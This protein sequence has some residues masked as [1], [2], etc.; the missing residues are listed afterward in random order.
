MCSSPPPLTKEV[1][2]ES[3]NTKPLARRSAGRKDSLALL[4]GLRSDKAAESALVVVGKQID[5]VSV[6][7]T[8]R[9]EGVGDNTYVKTSVYIDTIPD[10]LQCVVNWIPKHKFEVIGAFDQLNV[11]AKRGFVGHVVS[12]LQTQATSSIYYEI[13]SVRQKCVNGPFRHPPNLNLIASVTYDLR[14][15]KPPE[16]SQMHWHNN[17]KYELIVHLTCDR[18]CSSVTLTR[19]LFRDAFTRMLVAERVLH[20]TRASQQDVHSSSHYNR[21]SLANEQIV[22]RNVAAEPAIQTVPNLMLSQSVFLY[23]V[24]RSD[25]DCMK[26][27]F[28]LFNCGET[29]RKQRLALNAW[30]A[31]RKQTDKDWNSYTR[32]HASFIQQV[33]AVTKKPHA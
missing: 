2:P 14:K 22:V 24:P 29:H 26:N 20:E 10:G 4:P 19:I 21:H 27:V 7:S 32:I 8:Q 13:E 9:S 28:N 31:L 5:E 6:A 16:H 18:N 12:E 11:S 17:P 30:Q 23:P 15:K 1:S 3:S 33:R 25:F